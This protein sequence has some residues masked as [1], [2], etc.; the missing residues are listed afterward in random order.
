MAGL[1]LFIIAGEASGDRLGAEL[2]RGVRVLQPDARFTG[3]G[4][5]MMA[6]QGLDS[7]FPMADLSVMGISEIV[8]HLPKLLRRASE[9]VDAVLAAGPDALVTVDSPGF[10]LR[11]AAKV[12][13]VRPQ[14]PTIHYVAPSVWAWRPKRAAH[15]AGFIDH[16]LALLPFEPPYMTAAGMTCDFVGHPVVADRKASTGEIA[17]LRRDLGLRAGQKLLAL[18]P[19]SR[20]GEIDRMLPVFAQVVASLQRADP[21]LGAVVPAA[22]GMAARLRA[23]FAGLAQVSVLDPDGLPVSVSE[24]RKRASF[25]ASDAALATS[26]TVALELAAAGTPMVIAYKASA[27]TSFFLQRITAIDSPTI[28]N[29]VTGSHA[30]P[31]FLFG[32]CT[33]GKIVPVVQALL[34]RSGEA[35]EQKAAFAATMLALGA[36]GEAPGLRAAKSVMAAVRK[37]A[38]NGP[39]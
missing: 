19:G 8:R 21:H 12:K 27:L 4:G 18:L 24:A 33:A 38:R 26:G 11:V 30:V 13:A 15:M 10:C 35:A 29:I 14:L 39:A 37:L 20:V 3:I 6:E 7:L 17:T 1:H 16:V 9:T 36:G 22:P 23:G 31:D 28:V 25:A 34:D 32:E 2:M 5:V